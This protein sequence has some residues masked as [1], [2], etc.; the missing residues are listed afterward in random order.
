PTNF[1]VTRAQVLNKVDLADAQITWSATEIPRSIG[2]SP[3]PL[4]QQRIG[5]TTRAASS[6]LCGGRCTA[7]ALHGNEVDDRRGQQKQR[8]T[9]QPEKPRAFYVPHPS[10]AQSTGSPRGLNIILSGI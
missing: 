3:S 10:N 4:T 8:R 2:Q 1:D 7:L 9:H 6:T 5:S